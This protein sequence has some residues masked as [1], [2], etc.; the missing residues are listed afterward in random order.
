MHGLQA[1]PPRKPRSYPA[2][3]SKGEPTALMLAL[4]AGEIGEEQAVEWVERNV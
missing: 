2:I 1:A 3:S 4:D